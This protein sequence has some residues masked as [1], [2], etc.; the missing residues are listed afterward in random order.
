MKGSTVSL[1]SLAGLLAL[2][3]SAFAHSLSGSGLAAGLAHPFLGADHLLAMVA[4][5]IWAATQSGR[6]QLAVP[7][8]FLGALLGG[9]VLGLA[10]VPLPLVETGIALSVLLLGLLLASAVRLP[11]SVTLTLCALFALFH[12]HAHGAEAVGAAAAFAAGFLASSLTLHLGGMALTRLFR[13]RAPLI[14]RSLGLAIAASGAWM[15]S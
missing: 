3:G 6:M 2:P 10:S 1:A 8:C 13:T 12:G 5:G 11:A 7:L 4:I 9:F 15:L 14:A